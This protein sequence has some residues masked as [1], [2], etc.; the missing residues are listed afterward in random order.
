LQVNID[1]LQKISTPLE[2]IVASGGLTWYDGLC[3]R[4]SDLSG[5]PLYRPASY[6]AT[7]RGTAWLLAGKPERW[8]E[9]EPGLWFQS[10][11]NTALRSRCMRWRAAMNAALSD[12][13]RN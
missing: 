5:L 3:Q 8:E 7:A 4:L 10:Q 1:L 13:S 6:E 11:V 9:P 2:R 12:V